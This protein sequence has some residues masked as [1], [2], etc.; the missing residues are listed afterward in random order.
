MFVTKM[1]H[2]IPKSRFISY[3]FQQISLLFIRFFAD[4]IIIDS[5][6]LKKQLIGKGFLRSK[7]HVVYPGITLRNQN[8]SAKK[9]DGVF[10][11]RLHKS[12]GID[13]ILQIWKN[14][15]TTLPM[16]KLAIIGQ[17]SKKTISNLNKQIKN[18]KLKQNID[19]LGFL[20]DEKAFSI[21]NSCKV[22]LFPSHEEGFGM[23]VGEVLSCDVPIVAYDLPVFNETFK[24]YIQ[25][26]S[27]FDKH[28]FSEIT[29]NILSKKVDKGLNNSKNILNKLSWDSAS[30]YEY[31]L[32][33]KKLPK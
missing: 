32:I 4:I 6:I 24:S 19:L 20:P 1:F 17:G 28:K 12:K 23:I 29:I 10:M 30:D 26:V 13:D 9:Y 33:N 15:T 14:V 31:K 5:N 22:F 2:L 11:S 18:E 25:T 3:I 8:K 7:L 16:A 27:C 21:I